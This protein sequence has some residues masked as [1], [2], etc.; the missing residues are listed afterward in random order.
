MMISGQSIH[1]RFA[2]HRHEPG[3]HRDRLPHFRGQRKRDAGRHDADADR[4]N[5][6]DANGAADDVGAAVAIAEEAMKTS[7]SSTWASQAVLGFRC[8]KG[9]W[10]GAH[11]I[12]QSVKG[13]DSARVHAYLH[14]KEGDLENSNYWHARAGATMPDVPLEIEWEMLAVELLNKK[15][16]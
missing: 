12:V 8:A 10:N 9:D 2:F 4:R 7:P 11:E 16:D 15:P 13:K 1:D 5:V 14:R 3:H 6:V